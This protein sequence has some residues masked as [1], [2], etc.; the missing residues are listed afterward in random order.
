MAEPDTLHSPLQNL[1]PQNHG[2]LIVVAAY[3][4]LFISILGV[5]LKSGLRLAASRKVDLTDWA[6]LAGL[7]RAARVNAASEQDS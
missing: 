1:T 3:I 5:I 7:V 4:F 2:P 6:I